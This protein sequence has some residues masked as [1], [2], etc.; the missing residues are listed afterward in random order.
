MSFSGEV[1]NVTH[2]GS[3]ATAP[4]VYDWVR[5]F[6]TVETGLKNAMLFYFCNSMRL[7]HICVGVIFA[8]DCFTCYLKT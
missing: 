3:G 8:I 5:L 4:I 6:C 1:I 7:L 2:L